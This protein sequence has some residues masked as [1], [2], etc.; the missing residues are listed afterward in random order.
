MVSPGHLLL[1]L[2]LSIGLNQG[3]RDTCSNTTSTTTS[4]DTDQ[5]GYNETD[6]QFTAFKV[7]EDSVVFDWFIT[8]EQKER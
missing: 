3:A 2:L 7:L 6:M 1:A 8:L 4:I 5:L